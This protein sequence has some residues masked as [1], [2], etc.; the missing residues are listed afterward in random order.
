LKTW[1]G[2]DFVGELERIMSKLTRIAFAA[3]VLLLCGAVGC[4]NSLNRQQVSGQVTLD[5][6][7]LD[8]GIVEFTPQQP[9]GVGSGSEIKNGR[10]AIEAAR[11]LPPGRY[12]VRLYSGSREELAAPASPLGPALA[13]ATVARERIPAKYNTQSQLNVE[14]VGNKAN[15][16]DFQ[17]KTNG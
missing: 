16:L 8:H 14:V 11:G 5:G 10:Y 6:A 9:G 4:G 15:V 7:P 17:I 3:S 13:S 1:L 12:L 2:N